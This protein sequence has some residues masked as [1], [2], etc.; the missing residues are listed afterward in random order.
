MDKPSQNQERPAGNGVRFD[1]IQVH[2]APEA[3][4]RQIVEQIRSGKLAPGDCLPSQRELARMFA[5]GLGS[6][7]EA[8][9]ILDVM[10]HLE[11]VRGKGTFVASNGVSQTPGRSPFDK[12]MEAVSL[13]DLMKA[14]EVVESGAARMAAVRADPESVERLR[15][16]TDRMRPDGQASDAYY[17]NDFE[18]HLAVAETANNPAMSEIVRLLVDK[19]HHHIGFMNDALGIAMPVNVE[20]CVN[21]ARKVARCIEQGDGPGADQAMREHLNVVNCEL[22]KE[23]PGKP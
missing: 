21:T 2:S 18:F 6:V 14:R 11:V 3:L 9:K 19:S 8:V 16:I 7:R 20:R 23:F 1:A 17:H 15:E 10:G 12:A 13:A 4:A 22:R 5:V